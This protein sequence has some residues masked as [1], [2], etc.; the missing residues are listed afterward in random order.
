MRVKMD[1]SIP[2]HFFDSAG[3]EN[4]YESVSER[5][6]KAF[7]YGILKI[8]GIRRGDPERHEPDYLSGG[9]GYEVTFAVRDSI[10]PQLKGRKELDSTPRATETELIS[11]I[12]MAVERKAKKTYSVKPSLVIITLS[13][14]VMW[15]PSLFLKKDNWIDRISWKMCTA[16]RDALFQKLYKDYILLGCFDDIFIIQPTHNQ[17]FAFF[18]IRDFGEGK[19][20]FM[21]HVEVQNPVFFPTYRV[22][23]VSHKNG[24]D[25]VYVDITVCKYDI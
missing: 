17:T 4:D 6:A 22:K 15:Q 23:E 8:D 7:L 18:G 24:E 21:V 16:R 13:N 12:C 5:V 20:G 11:D 25:E 1:L 10:I 3:P 2:P 9:K 14:L 19:D